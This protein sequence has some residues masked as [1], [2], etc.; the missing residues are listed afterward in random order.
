MAI[1]AVAVMFAKPNQGWL[2]KVTPTPV[3]SPT[4]V[5]DPDMPLAL[6]AAHKAISPDATSGSR[7]C[8][9]S[10]RQRLFHTHETALR[11]G[12][13]LRNHREPKDLQPG[14]KAGQ[15]KLHNKWSFAYMF[16]CILS[17]RHDRSSLQAPP[18]ETGVPDERATDELAF[19]A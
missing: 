5:R 7:L 13:P 14:A 8:V 12:S 11:K 17:R 10:T 1:A 18:T 15:P 3:M 6:R 4:R 2:I 16:F 9:Q 19:V